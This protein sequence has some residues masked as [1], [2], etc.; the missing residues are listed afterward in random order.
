MS[1]LYFREPYSVFPKCK[2]HNLLC[3]K[4]NELINITPDLE[5]LRILLKNEPLI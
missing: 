1:E 4:K 3:S 2:E 5:D